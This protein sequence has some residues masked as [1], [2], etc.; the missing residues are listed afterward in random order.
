MR[1]QVKQWVNIKFVY[2]FSL[3]IDRLVNVV[4]VHWTVCVLHKLANLLF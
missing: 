2:Y 1:R 3:M 4:P